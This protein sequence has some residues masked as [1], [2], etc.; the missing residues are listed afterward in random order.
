MLDKLFGW[1]DSKS[2]LTYPHHA[3]ITGA[4]RLIYNYNQLP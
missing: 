1:R 4:C 3:R 2:T